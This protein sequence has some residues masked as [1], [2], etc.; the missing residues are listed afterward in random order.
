MIAIG[1]WVLRTACRQL[2]RLTELGYRS[3]RMA[4]NVSHTQFREPG[5]VSMVRRVLDDCDV[6]AELLEL[7]LTESVSIGHIGSTVAK[8]AEI[9]RM[10]ISVAL[11]DFGT[12]YSSLSVLKQLDVDRIKIDRSFV[13]GITEDGD[14]TGI[15]RLVIALA[16]QLDL[17][18]IAEGV[19]S[20]EQRRYLL[21]LGCKEGQG[22]LFA[23]AMPGERFIQWLAAQDERRKPN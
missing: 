11:D 23:P 16:Q 2:K 10:G 8:I 22:Y 6:R 7:K 14:E 15:S 13:T 9:R 12:G 20:E 3:F 19:E 5:F 21:H 18:T 4:V 1:E 17:K